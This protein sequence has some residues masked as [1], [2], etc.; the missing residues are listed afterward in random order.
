MC[1]I[2]FQS[3]SLLLSLLLSP[4]H[5]HS[6]GGRFFF[7]IYFILFARYTLYGYT[8][9]VWLVVIFFCYSC[10]VY[11]FSFKQPKHIQ[12]SDFIR[13][14]NNKSFLSSSTGRSTGFTLHALSFSVRVVRTDRQSSSSLCF[15]VIHYL[16]CTPPVT[17][18]TT[19]AATIISDTSICPPRQWPDCRA[20]NDNVCV[21][22]YSLHY[23]IS[24]WNEKRG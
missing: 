13:C 14:V 16:P 4:S 2:I 9:S 17:T 7:I 19:A 12:L 6:L 18:T 1:A 21:C 10:I 8:Y 22:V 5:F 20:C 3:L 23:Y 15:T 24:K 11:Y